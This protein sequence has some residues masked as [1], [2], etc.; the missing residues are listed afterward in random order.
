MYLMLYIVYVAMWLKLQVCSIGSGKAAVKDCSFPQV[1][2]KHGT[3]I[4]KVF[5]TII[6]K[7]PR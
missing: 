4:D 6:E 3:G 7:I 2:A 1:S 5:S